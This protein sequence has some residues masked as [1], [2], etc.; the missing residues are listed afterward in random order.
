MPNSSLSVVETGTITGTPTNLSLET[1]DSVS[2][3]MCKQ[4]MKSIHLDYFL[5]L[6]NRSI[7]KASELGYV[8]PGFTAL[9]R[10]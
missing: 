1:T 7:K 4:S 2:G 6:V 8:V 5:W 3:N 9:L 10:I